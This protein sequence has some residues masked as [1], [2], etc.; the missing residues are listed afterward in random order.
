MSSWV[1]FLL[2]SGGI[3]GADLPDDFVL[4]PPPG[5]Y[6]SSH[7]AD[8]T[9]GSDFHS[10]RPLVA[11]TYFYWYDVESKAHII[12]PDGSDALTHHPPSLD[13]FSYKNV[14]WHA[15]QL[16]DMIAAGVDV[17]L[18]VYWGT[19]VGGF[20]F[21][22][23]GLP[24]LVAAREK[25]LAEGH[26]PPAIGMFY[27]TTTLRHNPPRYHVD[28]TTPAGKRWFYGTIRNFFSLVPPEHRATIDGRPLVFLYTAAFAKRVDETLFPSVQRMFH[29]DFGTSLFL[30]KM[31]D[32]PGQADS[33]YRWGGAIRPQFLDTAALGPGYDHSAVPGRKPLVRDR[34]NGAFYSRAWEQLLMR[35]PKT[36]PW[37]VHVETWNELHEGTEVCHSLECGR[38]Y[39]ELT[40][41]Y[42]DMFRAGVRIDPAHGN[43]RKEV[44]ATLDRLDGLRPVDMP[45][46]DGP[47][48]EVVVGNVRAWST[49]PNRFSSMRYMYF[50]VAPELLFDD[51]APV[52]V[53]VCYLDSGPAAF[54]LD[55]DSADPK[56]QGLPQAFRSAGSRAISGSGRWCKTQFHL[57]HARFAGRANGADFRLAADGAELVV[58][59]VRVR[60][61]ASPADNSP[62]Q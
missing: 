26:R 58:A 39:I 29:D 24:P 41:K 37:L 3:I 36:R 17:V 61:V 4:P 44:S 8:E 40:R 18:P 32:W 9:A 1:L 46:G 5:K 6:V 28:L 19:P 12:N 60:R 43:R 14:A 25:L 15:G 48:V 42:A 56:L 52:E 10:G 23:R 34:E 35:N 38:Q 7:P 16:R 50:D 21:S 51:D 11:T 13:G 55:Y 47:L 27:D 33:T 2:V 54:R 59:E 62:A 31:S 49:K 45:D 22:N 30:V 53:T 57:E 20:S